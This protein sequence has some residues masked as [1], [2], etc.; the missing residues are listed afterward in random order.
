MLTECRRRTS[1]HSEN[2]SKE[3]EEHKKVPNRSWWAEIN[4]WT[5][6]YNRGTQQSTRWGKERDG[7]VSRTHPITAEKKIFNEGSLIY[8]WD[9]IKQTNIHII[10][11]PEDKM[12][13][14]NLL[15]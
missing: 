11:I 9:D 2:Y 13:Q 10:E 8:L 12:R 14:K 7:Q 15:K 5:E 3:M 6:K 4:N 1:E